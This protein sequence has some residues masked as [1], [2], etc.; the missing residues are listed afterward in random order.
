MPALPSHRKLYLE[1]GLHERSI[2]MQ[3]LRPGSAKNNGFGTMSHWEGLAGLPQLA[4][5]SD[6]IV[7]EAEPLVLLPRYRSSTEKRRSNKMERC[8]MSNFERY[9]FIH[10]LSLADG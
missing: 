5:T 4:K 6:P 2:S 10:T 8:S 1:M 3:E 9:G 7:T